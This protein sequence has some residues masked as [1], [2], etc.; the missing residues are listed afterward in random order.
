[1]ATQKPTTPPLGFTPAWIA[2]FTP[3]ASVD[4]LELGDKITGARMLR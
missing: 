4:R 2:S 1:M 3:P